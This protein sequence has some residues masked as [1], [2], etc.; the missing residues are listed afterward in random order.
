MTNRFTD[1]KGVYK[2]AKMSTSDGKLALLKC[3]TGVLS[4]VQM[5]AVG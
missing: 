1:T 5:S 2:F 4:G 3:K